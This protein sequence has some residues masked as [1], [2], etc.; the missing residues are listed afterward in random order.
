LVAADFSLR[1]LFCSS[2]PWLAKKVVCSECGSVGEITKKCN[3]MVVAVQNFLVILECNN[4]IIAKKYNNM[5]VVLQK[6]CLIFSSYR[7][8]SA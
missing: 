3:N 7:F 8:Y 5:V 1:K 4:R 2:K 6:V